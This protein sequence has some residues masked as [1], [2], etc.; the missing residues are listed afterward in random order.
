LPNNP[1][2]DDDDDFLP[3]TSPL[4][5]PVSER[6]PVSNIPANAPVPVPFPEAVVPFV[7]NTTRQEE[8]IEDEP[9]LPSWNPLD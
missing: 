5:E 9:E 7:P 3:A 8:A 4:P 6:E 2:L 1:Y